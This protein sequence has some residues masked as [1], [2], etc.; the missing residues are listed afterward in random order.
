MRGRLTMEQIENMSLVVQF[1]KKILFQSS[2]DD[3]EGESE[4]QHDAGEKDRDEEDRLTE[5]EKNKALQKQLEVGHSL[6]HFTG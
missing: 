5:S 6:V 2:H 4:F 1:F 3:Q